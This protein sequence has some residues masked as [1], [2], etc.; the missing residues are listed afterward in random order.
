MDLTIIT[1]PH[2]D[3]ISLLYRHRYRKT[4]AADNGMCKARELARTF[5]QNEQFING[6]YFIG[7]VTAVT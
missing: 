4:T 5:R 7:L 1:H 3:V 2:D 6:E